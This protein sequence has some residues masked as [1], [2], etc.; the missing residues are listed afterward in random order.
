MPDTS[1]WI[2]DPS[3]PVW[4][5]YYA[6]ANGAPVPE[7]QGAMGGYTPPPA[8]KAPTAADNAQAVL[9]R[10][11]KWASAGGKTVDGPADPKTGKPTTIP[12]DPT[13]GEPDPDFPTL[14]QV[15]A[16]RAE[17][18][19][20]LPDDPAI[21]AQAAAT[22]DETLKRTQKI[23]AE[24]DASKAKPAKP[25][26]SP[27]E[28]VWDQTLNN[29][30]GGYTVPIASKP[31][32]ATT[33][34]PGQA[35]LNPDGTWTVPV[36]DTSKDT[37]EGAHTRRMSEINQTAKAQGQA[38]IDAA[39]AKVDSGIEMT[40]KDKL[41]LQTKLDGIKSDHDAKI[42]V[43][44]AKFTHDLAEPGA[45]ESRNTAQQNADAATSNAE[46]TAAN[47]E[48]T[49]VNQAE[50][51]ARANRQDAIGALT[52]QAAQGQANMDRVV[53]AGAAQP[54][55]MATMRMATQPLELAF[56]LAHQAVATGAL[57]PTAIPKP[58]GAPAPAPAAA[59]PP[60]APLPAPGVA[61][62]QPLGGPY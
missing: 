44:A 41:E 29:G 36:A 39:K 46:S 2:V 52:S 32:A 24:I 1:R 31:A 48:N 20:K 5:G 23:Q 42:A 18:I 45:Q 15:N 17:V 34:S 49:R 4:G 27:G 19:A 51:A 25:N 53:K 38:L 21:K 16:A 7:L 26:V 33:V 58:N 47:V 9:A 6:D 28:G 54:M 40:E 12:V 37:P 43:A 50:Q 56:Q 60:Q 11:W 30:A 8:G 10:Y 59:G 62:P 57:P 14:E 55:S 13:T 61:A 3:V 35:V 22:L